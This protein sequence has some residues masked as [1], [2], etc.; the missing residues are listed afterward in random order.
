MDSI[1]PTMKEYHEEY[2]KV[3]EA[4][5][6]MSDGYS[7]NYTDMKRILAICSLLFLHLQKHA[8]GALSLIH[9]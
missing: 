6:L 1:G 7:S 9:I 8:V 3:C 4:G 5:E 2:L